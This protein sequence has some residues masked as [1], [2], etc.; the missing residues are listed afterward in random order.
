M[1]S[2]LDRL[3]EERGFDALIVYGPAEGNAPLRYLSNGAKVTHATVVKKRGEQPVLVVGGMERDEAARSGL[4][5]V[6]DTEFNFHQHYKDTGDRFETTL[7]M[8]VEMFEHFDLSGTVSFYGIS[9]P[10]AALVFLTELGKRLPHVTLTGEATRSIF[11]E[12]GI[13]K[14][15]DEI[16]ALHTVAERT[17]A[18]MAET[19]AFIRSHAVEDEQL[20]KEDGTPLT[21]GDV[22]RQVR[23]R[24]LYYGLEEAHDMIFAIG[25]DGGVPHSRGEENAPLELGKAI[26]FDLFPRD[27]VTGYFHDMTRTF[28]LGYAAEEVQHAYEQV[29]QAFNAVMDELAVGQPTARYQDLVCDI[30]EEHGHKT[31]RSE[32]GT[33]EGYVHSLGHGIGI[34]LHES[35]TFRE[36]SE[37]ILAAGQVFTIEPGLYYPDKGFGIRVEDTIYIDPEGGIHSL[38][39]TPKDLVI[40]I[41]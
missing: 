1:K 20:L 3:M 18:V 15:A 38:T 19:I 36:H 21:V 17:N 27:P 26:V 31:P 34:N 4:P 6:L 30:F 37:D 35:P 33:T 9:S 5:I 2:D 10:G 24:L 11:D 7:R 25:R 29:M 28:S 40:P 14:D 39:P 22:K 13:T 41:P 8:Y 16:A 23:A 12:A 32:P